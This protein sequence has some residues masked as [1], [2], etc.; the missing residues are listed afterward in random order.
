MEL[1][2]VALDLPRLTIIPFWI[3]PYSFTFTLSFIF[4]LFLISS[5]VIF[6]FLIC[7]IYFLI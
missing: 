4:R 2:L 5:G 1:L 7:Y 6:D 3:L